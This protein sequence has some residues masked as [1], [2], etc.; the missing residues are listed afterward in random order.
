M[1]KV[2]FPEQPSCT[3][4][5]ARAVRVGTGTDDLSLVW[6]EAWLTA[7]FCVR[8]VARQPSMSMRLFAVAL[9]ASRHGASAHDYQVCICMAACKLPAAC[10]ILCLLVKRLRPIKPAAERLETNFH[11]SFRDDEEKDEVCKVEKG[12]V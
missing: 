1:Q 4:R 8:L 11:V 9:G 5:Y 6:A 2:H 10:E 12:V 3:L 7:I